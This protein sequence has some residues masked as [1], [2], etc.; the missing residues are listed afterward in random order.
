MNN[1]ELKPQSQQPSPVS[2]EEID[3]EVAASKDGSVDI[4]AVMISYGRRFNGYPYIAASRIERAPAQGERASVLYN[5]L[6]ANHVMKSL[7]NQT[8]AM[9]DFMEV[10]GNGRLVF[11]Q[12]FT[13]CPT[14]GADG[15]YSSIS[16]NGTHIKSDL[17]GYY[18]IADMEAVPTTD[19][20]SEEGYDYLYRDKNDQ[21][22]DLGVNP[23]IPLKEY[24]ALHTKLLKRKH[25]PDFTPIIIVKQGPDKFGLITGDPY[26]PVPP[27]VIAEVLKKQA[28]ERP[29]QPT[30][31][32]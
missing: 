26:P 4:R 15:L 5:Q 29:Q 17:V 22:M 3:A 18:K 31:Q 30:E 28:V 12:A 16:I 19:E 10:Y 13:E 14:L 20:T 7:K 32:K 2:Q 25:K 24:Y 11:F 6:L 8:K 9:E 1:K 23:G 21:L 27:E